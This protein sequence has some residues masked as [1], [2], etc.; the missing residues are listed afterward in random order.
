MRGSPNY[1]H[2][3]VQD[4]LA[5]FDVPLNGFG[6]QQASSGVA[7]AGCYTYG[8]PS[9]GSENFREF[10]GTELVQPSTIVQTYF[11]NFKVS[12]AGEGFYYG[13]LWATNNI[14]ALFTT[15]PLFPTV[16][17]PLYSHANVFETAINVEGLSNGI[18]CCKA[19]VNK[20]V[21]TKTFIIN[22]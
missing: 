10:I 19:I 7:Y 3:C 5:L 13:P 16:N 9:G 2:S 8:N 15:V 11:V 14:G 4:S 1:F 6:Y 22:H 17:D 18:Y 12:W 21:V 20:R